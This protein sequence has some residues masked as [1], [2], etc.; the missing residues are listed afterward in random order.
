[1][2]ANHGIEKDLTYSKIITSLSS[3]ASGSGLK[4][5]YV[6][7]VDYRNLQPA[8]TIAFCKKD[9]ILYISDGS[10]WI[11]INGQTSQSVGTGV[12]LVK[13]V[14]NYREQLRTLISNTDTIAI[15]LT[16]DGSSISLD[17]NV[18]IPE[19]TT[20]NVLSHIKGGENVTITE[21]EGNY[22]IS[23]ATSPIS[24][25]LSHIRGNGNVTI[26]EVEGD[27]VISSP[28]TADI[29]SHIKA[30]SN[31]TITDSEGDLVISSQSQSS[32]SEL[33]TR[34]QGGDNVTVAEVDGNLVI[35]SSAISLQNITP[36]SLLKSTNNGS[37]TSITNGTAG[38]ILALDENGD[39][40]WQSNIVDTIYQFNN[41]GSGEVLVSTSQLAPNLISVNTKTLLSDGSVS[42]QST[43][44]TVALSVNLTSLIRNPVPGSVIYTDNTGTVAQLPPASSGQ[45]LKL[46]NGVPEWSDSPQIPPEK[47]AESVGTGIGIYKGL[48]EN[49]FQF[50]NI[51]SSSSIT[52]NDDDANNIVLST[53]LNALVPELTPGSI[54]YVN[55]SSNVSTFPV[56]LQDQLLT[57]DGTGNLV[58]GNLGNVG[59]GASI[60]NSNNT[61]KTLSST[62]GSVA[63]ANLESGEL[64]ITT[65]FKQILGNS[66]PSPNAIL[67]TN[68]SGELCTVNY[69][70]QGQLLTATN[71][72]Y[73]W[74][75]PSYPS[76]DAKGDGVSIN[77]PLNNNT[78]GFKTLKSNG[79]I[80]INDSEDVIT[81][82]TALGN[83]VPDAQAGDLLF[84]GAVEFE[85]VHVGPRRHVLTSDGTN[86]V[87]LPA[88]SGSSTTT[89][90]V[91]KNPSEGEFDNI[92]DAVNSI[93]ESNVNCPY[94]IK[95]AS[96]VYQERST[97]IFKPYVYIVGE[98]IGGVVI[99][100]LSEGYDLFR[101]NKAT[102]L[103]FCSISDVASPNYACV[104]SDTGSVGFEYALLHKV[105]FYSSKVLVQPVLED[106]YVYFE[107]CSYAQQNVNDVID[108]TIDVRS[109][110]SFV[111]YLSIENHFVQGDFSLAS[112]KVDGANSQLYGQLCNFVGN[113]RGDGILATNGGRV[114]IRTSFFGNFQNA[115]HL[116]LNG[117]NPSLTSSGVTFGDNIV[118]LNVK[119]PTSTGYLIGFSE[120]NKTLINPSAYNTFFI[121]N[122]NQRIVTVAPKG[123]NFTSISAA[124]NAINPVIRCTTSNASTTLKS[125]NLFTVLL[126]NTIVT[127]QGIQPGC[128]CTFVD[129]STLTL[130]L[131]ASASAV[132]DLTF[133]RATEYTAFTV[134]VQ[135]GIYVEHSPVFVGE[136]IN[137][138]GVNRDTCVCIPAIPNT[139]LFVISSHAS[140]SN[141]NITGVYPERHAVIFTDSMFSFADNIVFYEIGNAISFEGQTK[142]YVVEVRNC[143]FVGGSGT[144][145]ISV[146]NANPPEN[147]IVLTVTFSDLRC[148]QHYDS[149]F[150]MKGFNT[151]AVIRNCALVGDGT[152]D[153]LHISDSCRVSVQG[154]YIERWARGF[155]T[156]DITTNNPYLAIEGMTNTLV[157]GNLLE[158]NN[159]S[160]SGYYSGYI[161]HAQV[162]IVDDSPFFVCNKDS[163]IITVAKKGG[164]YESIYDAIESITNASVSNIYTILVGPGI[165]VEPPLVMK[166]FTN[167]KGNGYM[168]SIIFCNDAAG[169][170]ITGADSSIVSGF[171][172]N[173]A[174]AEGGRA[175]YLEGNGRAPGSPFIVENCILGS[176]HT[177][178]SINASSFPA[179]MILTE[180][181]YGATFD[182]DEGVKVVGQ[183]SQIASLLVYN[184]VFQ[185]LVTPVPQTLLSCD[186]DNALLVASNT[187]IQLN[188]TNTSV[189][190]RMRNGAGVRLYGCSVV[191]L[192]TGVISENL[193]NGPGL[194]VS[195]T[196]F[197]R[198]EKI[199][200]IENP[201]TTGYFAGTIDISKSF[202]HPRSTFNVRDRV[203]NTLVVSEMGSDYNSVNSAILSINPVISIHV[204]SGSTSISPVG[205]A[206]FNPSM[207]GYPVTGSGIPPNTTFT[208]V[209]CTS[210]TLSNAIDSNLLSVVA[211]QTDV[212]DMTVIRSA[213]TNP[214]VVYLQPGVYIEPPITLPPY[215]SLEGVSKTTCIIHTSSNTSPVVIMGKETS[216]N[217]L[218]IIGSSGGVGILADS[219]QHD[220]DEIPAEIRNVIIKDCQQGIFI[221]AT[222][223]PC[224]VKGD[225][226]LIAGH[227][228]LGILVDGSTISS[229]HSINAIFTDLQ[230]NLEDNSHTSISCEG[231]N[232]TLFLN[233]SVV[234]CSN[235]SA[236]TGISISDGATLILN[237]SQIINSTLDGLIV[238]S[239]GDAPNLQSN[240]CTF[241]QNSGKDIH[242]Q[243]PSA[244]GCITMA[245][246]QTSK[247]S[248]ASGCPITI[249]YVDP[250]VNGITMLGAINIGNNISDSVNV[251]PALTE[252][253]TIGVLNGG[254]ITIASNNEITISKGDGY[255][256]M[257]SQ[258]TPLVYVEWGDVTQTISG[259]QNVNY[260]YISSI[261]TVSI[262]PSKQLT[263][264]YLY[265]GRVICEG[266][267]IAFV[268][269]TAMSAHHTANKYDEFHRSALGAVVSGGL[270]T[271]VNPDRSVVVSAGTYFLSGSKIE[272]NDFSSLTVSVVEYYHSNSEFQTLR[273][274]IPYYLDNTS[275]DNLTELTAMTE[276]YYAKHSVYV[277]PSRV[278]IVYAQSQYPTEDECIRSPSPNPPIYFNESII[279]ISDIIT[280]QGNN[281]CSKVIDCRPVI[282]SKISSLGSTLV[283]GNLQ[284]LMEDDHPQYLRTDGTRPISGTLNMNSNDLINV[285]SINSIDYTHHAS[286]H[287]PNGADPLNTASPSV[288]LGCASTN[289]EGVANSFARSDHSHRILTGNVVTQNPD[290]P[291]S[292]GTSSSFA[293]S[294]HIHNIPADIAVD[295][296]TINREGT[297]SS[298]ARADH[299]HL[300]V[301]SVSVGGSNMFGDITINSGNGIMVN[302]SSN[303]VSVSSVICANEFIVN[304]QSGLVVSITSGRVTLPNMTVGIVPSTSL[305]LPASTSG[306]IFAD[307]TGAVRCRV[308]SVFGKNECP[309]A[310]FTTNSGSVASL[311]DVRVSLGS[312][313]SVGSG[314]TLVV[315]ITYGHNLSATRGGSPYA[316]ID[317]AISNAQLGD[318][319]LVYPGTYV[320]TSGVTLPQ[321]VSL[322]GIDRE[323]CILSFSA[324][325]SL[326]GITMGV[327]TYVSDLKVLVSSSASSILLTGILFE[328]LTSASARVRNCI[329]SV[330]CSS[331]AETNI[332]GVRS[333]GTNVDNRGHNIENSSIIITSSGTV[334]VVR[335]VMC[336]S[337]SLLNVAGTSIFVSS[338]GYGIE[339]CNGG[340]VR[341][342]E[343]EVNVSVS[344]NEVLRTSGTISLVGTKFSRGMNVSRTLVVDDDTITLPSGSDSLITLNASQTLTNKTLTDISNILTASYL[345]TTGSDVRLDLSSPPTS[346]Y[347]LTATSPTSASWSSPVSLS[348]G[349]GISIVGTT[350]SNTGITSISNSDGTIGVRNTGGNVVLSS[351]YTAG[352][353]IAITGSVISSSGVASLTAANSTV[354]V[355]GTSTNPT[356]SGNYTSGTGI[357]IDASGVITNTSP[358]SNISIT[359][360]GGTY[361]LIGAGISPNYTLK[362]LTPGVG[363]TIGTNSTGIT[364][365]NA[366]PASSVLLSSAGVGS[367]SNSLISRGT[368]PSIATKGLIA[369]SGISLSSNTTD[370][371]ISCNGVTGVS[372]G[373]TTIIVG[374]TSNNPTITGNYVGGAGI[375][376]SGNV[377]SGSGVVNV[378]AGN[379]TVIVGGTTNN[380]TIT[381]NYVGGT[382]V[383]I[384]GNTISNSSPASSVSLSSVGL[385]SNTQSLVVGGSGTSLSIKGISSGSGISL[386]GSSVSDI[387]ITNTGV[388]TISAGTGIVVGGTTTNPVVSVSY[389]RP[390]MVFNAPGKYAAYTT[391]YKAIAHFTWVNALYS[392]LS[393]GT[394]AYSV[395]N[396]GLNIQVY[397]V[398]TSTVL[399]SDTNVSATGV[400]TFTFTNPSADAI[401][402]IQIAQS[403]SGNNAVISGVQWFWNM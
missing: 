94:V 10:S 110:S 129:E 389:S 68:N 388:N 223:G 359:S 58:W 50:K 165:F 320:M 329:I 190:L 138:S 315:D 187:M 219:T 17:L 41:T 304:I 83:I 25:I 358:A 391:T 317:A 218:T 403:A 28:S 35:S 184:C 171:T 371:T 385:A 160:L 77:L 146:N 277:T 130:S 12:G 213:E 7:C 202:I 256:C 114:D 47:F 297:S 34:I 283:H 144:N 15:S 375:S 228:S 323:R 250:V 22:V 198:C 86:P 207:D 159:P 370:I 398:T 205:Q 143:I 78:Y 23:A 240:G 8:G 148:F 379:S 216:I 265:L 326:T 108:S 79:T 351:S 395:R 372:A 386:T 368:G 334:G 343:G 155:V 367:S 97:I 231:P 258:N 151:V 3:A 275:Y 192:Q 316:T 374:G 356:I 336:D 142:S 393:G 233:S 91:R 390:Q 364:I 1:M 384:I 209:S 248:V 141:L 193:G 188:G 42:I 134:L 349:T 53:S 346:G 222:Q 186:G 352:T 236:S 80:S 306:V 285:R 51:K 33:L 210:G 113:N 93:G 303:S 377:I 175:I 172:F 221:T 360:A 52:V 127:G 287:L 112:V 319:I 235:K 149:F 166:S 168:S 136:F 194:V 69:G 6:S 31:I 84:R 307:Y 259:S 107:Y 116:D 67:A 125:D 357:S 170:V 225:G 30:G 355:G 220:T 215:A 189:G 204:T 378:S 89:I 14:I 322:I 299:T 63:F 27:L 291:N 4:I 376:I 39:P 157:S 249:S 330:S 399:G 331:T 282:T 234:D 182:A 66:N 298:F 154:I 73:E 131:P 244:N 123:G 387:V 255:V 185:D 105:N 176:N 288:S 200:S 345:R 230:I 196:S 373:N 279:H 85:T 90:I 354:I 247:V 224:R 76:S 284:G 212:V 197:E 106:S 353:G 402:E 195:A 152:G 328:G 251:F 254:L 361:S 173:G 153:A 99:Q 117:T 324:S 338:I 325:S 309:I 365:S 60:L 38:M 139:S 177:L 206:L 59:E 243:H 382:G 396:A 266:G 96:G 122:S 44:D 318:T 115:L 203:T 150:D 48:S 98:D 348:S 16:P 274:S 294:D 245:T 366:S 226:V 271:T 289:Y 211:A 383:V 104:F 341:K 162:N 101:F 252:G 36:N 281:G 214:Y 264:N 174:T 237:S 290:Q 314:N 119:N 208:Y 164:D 54:V 82:T 19:V 109:S 340:V 120:Y 363:I 301:R 401:I 381:G 178:L 102:A 181:L 88:Q 18:A 273:S 268:E 263:L 201:F 70:T 238:L 158:I 140:I 217:N 362:G 133:L 128:V 292:E 269:N 332:Y 13:S 191:G 32:V 20:S 305:T 103:S 156:N 124:L 229:P 278:M 262:L 392:S 137:I 260:V 295:I 145:A 394:V 180:C 72:S 55:E 62:N 71:S 369:G 339:V 147:G 241:Y 74:A 81:L 397:N 313:V 227:G 57:V 310:T 5:P 87:W 199:L 272:F 11:P 347:V 302:A 126:H 2:A 333:N 118:N 65:S 37:I 337:T 161:A 49:T 132:V 169:A 56:G 246:A 380:P 9:N 312:R 21:S 95:V 121:A 239:D 163:K 92:V 311:T 257:D 344:G 46:V 135:S 61:F 29:L 75:N 300:G 179:V 43:S 280:Q 100:P 296:S 253:Q 40:H 232:S 293:R 270:T 342:R 24:G 261:G 111:S 321:G 400:R 267:N 335:G 167:L 26:S 286:R 45:I 242:I 327:D 308:G 350:I 64:D 183:N 276:G